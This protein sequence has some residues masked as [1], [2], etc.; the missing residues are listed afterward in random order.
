[1]SRKKEGHSKRKKKERLLFHLLL[2]LRVLMSKVDIDIVKKWLKDTKTVKN[3]S[4][5]QRVNERRKKK[6]RQHSSQT[7]SLNCLGQTY[8]AHGRRKRVR[9]KKLNKTQSSKTQST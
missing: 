4:R 1:M 2:P 3:C 7:K 9:A 5:N 8:L 6:E